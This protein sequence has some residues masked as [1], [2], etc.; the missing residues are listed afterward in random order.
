VFAVADA[1]GFDNVLVGHVAEGG[2][3]G[4]VVTLDGGEQVRLVTGPIEAP[5]GAAV[6]VAIPAGDILVA[7]TPPTGLSARN[8]LPA[9][10]EAVREMGRRRLALARVA[11]G[12]P[13]LAVALTEAACAE[14]GLVAGREVHLIIKA[15]ACS[16]YGGDGA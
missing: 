13:P 1:E 8:Q 14:L 9:T 15:N 12:V 5:P 7:T 3:D 11:P 6:L 2:G 10:L 4:G 16:V